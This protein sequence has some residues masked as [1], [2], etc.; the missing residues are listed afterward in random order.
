[1]ATYTLSTI[2]EAGT[3]ATY[4]AVSA[5]DTYTP[6][7]TDVNRI[8]ILHVKNAGGSPDTVTV[9]DPNSV[10]PAA[11]TAFNPDQT[12]SVPAGGDRFFRLDATRVR[13]T[14]TGAIT[15]TH[16]FTTSVTAA[17]LVV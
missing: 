14:G 5:S 9:D 12:G 16:S 1:M 10:T 7:A 8:H 4:T 3:N 11:A 2:S 13:N 15:I 6:A 17:I